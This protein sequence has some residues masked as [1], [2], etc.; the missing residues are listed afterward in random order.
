M[1]VQLKAGAELDMLSAG[2]FSQGTKELANRFR[3]IMRETEGETISRSAGPFSTDATGGTSTLAN[4]GGHVYRVPTGYDAYLTRLSV[5]FEGSSAAS[6][7]SCDLRIVADQ[8]TPAAL[9]AIFNSVP[10]VYEASKSHAPLFRGGQEVVV[11]LIG[12]PASTSIYCTAQ[13]LLTPRKAI[14]PDILAD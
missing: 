5:D 2:E 1:K 9:R 7:T 11:C 3:E 14:H 4:G 13:V 10:A 6:P 8:D 12:G